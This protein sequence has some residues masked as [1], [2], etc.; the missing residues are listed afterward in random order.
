MDLPEGIAISLISAISAVAGAGVVA[1]FNYLNNRM[2]MKYNREESRI[3]RLMDT[4]K[5]YLEPLR[6]N[7]AKA[8]EIFVQI[9]TIEGRIFAIKSQDEVDKAKRIELYMELNRKIELSSEISE[10]LR[11]LK[12]Q[13]SDEE[14]LRAIDDLFE[15]SKK[16]E[17][18]IASLIEIMNAHPESG[19][20]PFKKYQE[21]LNVLNQGTIKCNKLIE[22]LLSEI[23]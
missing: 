4:R 22:Q 21:Q 20:E 10:G 18:E 8:L 3:I 19:E 14:L 1:L 9:A 15:A 2:M 23:N 5:Q 6:I 13:I 11:G 16:S 17:L 12:Y 7:I